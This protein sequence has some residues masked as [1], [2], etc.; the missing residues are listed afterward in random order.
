M[1]LGYLV[2]WLLVRA[3]ASTYFHWRVYHQERVPREGPVL[4]VANHAS[5]LDPPFIGGTLRREVNYLARESLFRFP[6]AGAMLRHWNAVPVDREGGGAS[7]L[8]AILERLLAG[9]TVLLFPEGTRTPDGK[10]QSARA[11]VG[12]LIIK[13]RCPVVPVRVF[14]SH[15]AWGRHLRIPRPRRVTIKFGLPQDF[16]ALRAEA[17]TASRERLRQIYA[18]ATHQLMAS[19]AALEPCREV[20]RFP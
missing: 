15:E 16:A 12:L 14:G 7:G 17:R 9:G 11:G 3:T 13:S 10:L 2:P 8:R 5:F 4:L 1:K 20:A 18:T 19:I 6:V